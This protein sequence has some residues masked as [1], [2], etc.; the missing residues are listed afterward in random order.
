MIMKFK[1]VKIN[2]KVLIICLLITVLSQAQV[3]A[4]TADTVPTD[5]IEFTEIREEPAGTVTQADLKSILIQNIKLLRKL[6]TRMNSNHCG[7]YLLQ[8]LLADLPR[9]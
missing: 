2:L 6:I 1:I 4:K 8:D 7:V 3:Q 5:G 9:Y